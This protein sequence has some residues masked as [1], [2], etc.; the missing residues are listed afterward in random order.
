[1]IRL[2]PAGNPVDYKGPSTGAPKYISEEG[3]HAYEYQGTRGIRIS[4]EN[5]EKL[6]KNAKENDIWVTIHGQYWINFSSSKEETIEKSKDR[7]FKAARVGSLMGAKRV[8]FH[9]GYYSGR[10]G[11][12]AMKLTI[13]GIEEVVERLG[14][15]GI[16]IPIA[17]EITGKK[18]QVGSLDEIL[19]ICQEVSM[20]APTIDFAHIHARNNGS[21]KTKEDYLEVFERIEEKLGT[22]SVKNLHTHYTEV[23]FTDKGEKKHLKYGTEPSPSFK[24][25]AELIVENGYTPVIISES[26][27][28]DKDALKFKEVFGEI[29]YEF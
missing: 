2:G 13:E 9:P 11:E 8:V 29:G 22:D 6:G 15:E 12:E 24:P 4:E 7:L 5:S 27:L 21:I 16:E 28:L 25:L 1:M 23:K 10:S 3:L 17:P 20:T 18:S 14:G 26:P 19:E